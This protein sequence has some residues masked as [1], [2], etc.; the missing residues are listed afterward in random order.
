MRIEVVFR[1]FVGV[2]GVTLY[3]TPLGQCHLPLQLPR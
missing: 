3:L 1:S 2:C